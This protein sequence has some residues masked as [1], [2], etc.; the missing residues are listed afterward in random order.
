MAEMNSAT[1]LFTE[2][3]FYHNTTFRFSQKNSY[4]NKKRF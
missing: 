4:N 2:A 1:H 3:L